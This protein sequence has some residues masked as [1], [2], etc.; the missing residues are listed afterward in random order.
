M[1]NPTVHSSSVI[2]PGAK[3][4]ENCQIGPFCH[5]G[6][7]VTLHDGCRV[8]SHVSIMGRTTIGKD[9]TIHPTAVL[10]G[11]PQYLGYEGGVTDL[12]IGERC[13]IREGAT[14]ST[15]IPSFGGVTRLGNECL[16]LANSHVAHDCQLG[17]NVVL[18]NACELGGHVHIGDRAFVSSNVLI[19][20]YTRIG[21]GAFVGG[22]TPVKEDIIPFG[23][24][25]GNP[26]RLHGL[27]VIGMR[28]A[29]MSADTLRKTRQAYRI[30]FSGDVTLQEGVQQV[31]AEFADVPAVM[32]IVEFIKA[33]GDRPILA[34]ERS[35]RANG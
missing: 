8:L 31:E 10:G 21:R 11:E 5:I 2:E 14:I 25:N 13:I 6:P 34:P 20:Q 33:R 9:S 17:N 19:H 24:A 12:E 4:S 7:D 16:I 26:S 32:D 29:G 15:G 30:L 27:N 1:A 35:T 22:G 18:V 3:L 28:R 23:M